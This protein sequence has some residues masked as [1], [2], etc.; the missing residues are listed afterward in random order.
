[1]SYNDDY[2]LP[3]VQPRNIAEP[4]T[5]VTKWDVE[6]NKKH[7]RKRAIRN[8]R[9]AK[10]NGFHDETYVEL[11]AQNYEQP[12]QDQ[13]YV[14]HIYVDPLV[15]TELSEFI[16]INDTYYIQ[17]PTR[18]IALWPPSAQD[19]IHATNRRVRHAANNVVDWYTWLARYVR[20]EP[21][22]LPTFKLA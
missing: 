7:L 13:P 1:M 2:V 8:D 21:W 14:I 20:A 15:K 3:I 17:L 11:E 18:F 12:D 6:L 16:H 19:F 10:F 4:R 22:I 5:F 9:D